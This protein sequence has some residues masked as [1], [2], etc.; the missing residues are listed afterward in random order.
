[1]EKMKEN[2]R[3]CS[4]YKSNFSAILENDGKI[5]EYVYDDPGYEIT[6]DRKLKK[7]HNMEP[8][9]DAWMQIYDDVQCHEC[10]LSGKFLSA[11]K[12]SPVLTKSIP[13]SLYCCT[14]E[15]FGFGTNKIITRGTVWAVIDRVN[16]I[17]QAAAIIAALL[18]CGG[19]EVLIVIDPA[20]KEEWKQKIERFVE[21]FGRVLYDDEV[22][23]KIKI[24]DRVMH[25]VFADMDDLSDKNL[26][27]DWDLMIVDHARAFIDPE[28]NEQALEIAKNAYYRL[29]I[30]SGKM[31]DRPQDWYWIYRLAD[32]RIFEGSY[33]QYL[34]TYF[35]SNENVRMEKGSDLSFRLRSIAL[36]ED[37]IDRN[38][39]FF[40]E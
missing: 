23:D 30:A 35:D 2:Y 27:C 17:L 36:F 29:I 28:K 1:M 6:M 26:Y 4:W 11:P 7:E 33:E 25:I 12:L 14:C 19:R 34:E 21:L 40:G 32:P 15:H 16:R 39:P 9:D 10:P 37:W 13:D 18:E 24:Q 22:N 31:D 5:V 38:D 20:E 8:C 3:D